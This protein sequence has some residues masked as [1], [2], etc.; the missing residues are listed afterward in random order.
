MCG[1]PIG[2]K[3]RS[4]AERWV[5]QAGQTRYDQFAFYSFQN[6]ILRNHVQAFMDFAFASQSVTVEAQ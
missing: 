5:V 2:G 1:F 6:C 3:A 4:H